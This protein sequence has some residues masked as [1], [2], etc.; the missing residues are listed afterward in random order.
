MTGIK[1][2]ATSKKNYRG[3]VSSKAGST[4]RP[5]NQ[6]TNQPINQS[7]NQ[8]INQ[9]T[10]QPINQSTNQPINQSTTHSPIHFPSNPSN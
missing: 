10:N 5:I 2:H 4:S 8:P 3:I 7:T 1:S 9:S 6:S